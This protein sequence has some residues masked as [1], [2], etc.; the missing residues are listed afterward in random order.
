MFHFFPIKNHAALFS[1]TITKHSLR[2]IKHIWGSKHDH[3][4]YEVGKLITLARAFI[5]W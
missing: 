1:R 3:E 5:C 4:N 2:T